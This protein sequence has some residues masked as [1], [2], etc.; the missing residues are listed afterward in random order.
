[1]RCRREDREAGGIPLSA[2]NWPPGV[3]WWRGH[4][5]PPYGGGA[6]SSGHAEGQFDAPTCRRW[7]LQPELIDRPTEPPAIR[8]R[9]RQISGALRRAEPPRQ[10]RQEG[11]GPPLRGKEAG[12]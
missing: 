6:Q 7:R 11:E 10:G 1:M 5:D 4:R 9:F 12:R 3:V 8:V 2:W